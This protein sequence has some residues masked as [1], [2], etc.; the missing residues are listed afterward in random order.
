MPKP[1]AICIEDLDALAEARFLQCVALTG[2]QPGLRLEVG[3]EVTWLEAP[4]AAAELWVSQDRRLILYRPD[5]AAPV[6]VER[7]GRVL[8]APAEKPVVL[9]D[10]DRL[11]VGDR[12][13]CVHVHGVTEAVQA[14]TYFVPASKPAPAPE[15]VGKGTGLLHAAATAVA[16]GAVVGASGCPKQIEVRDHPPSAP[17]EPPPDAGANKPAPKPDLAA[18]KPDQRI[19]KKQPK[20]PIEVRVRPPAAVAD[21]SLSKPV[22]PP[23]P[24]PPK[25]K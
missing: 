23:K 2:R 12:R 3:G 22:L 18:I 14:P 13:L 19:I 6:R 17:Y 9:I 20:P 10:Q 25:G 7:D 8:D 24:I 5:G 1:I 21:P 11:D 15:A 16:I 4:V